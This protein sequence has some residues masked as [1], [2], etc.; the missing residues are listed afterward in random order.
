MWIYL[1]AIALWWP[2]QQSTGD[3]CADLEIRHDQYQKWKSDGI[4]L[5]LHGDSTWSLDVV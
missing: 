3:Y 5:V 2:I 1:L 4:D